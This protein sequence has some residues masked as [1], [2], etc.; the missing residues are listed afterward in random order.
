M[1]FPLLPLLKVKNNND[2]KKSRGRNHSAVTITISFAA[3]PAPAKRIGSL[4][5][6]RDKNSGRAI[7]HGERLCGG[8]MG[9]DQS[10]EESRALQCQQ[11]KRNYLD[12]LI[13]RLPTEVLEIYQPMR[14][15]DFLAVTNERIEGRRIRWSSLQCRLSQLPTPPGAIER[16]LCVRNWFSYARLLRGRYNGF[17]T[18]FHLHPLQVF[19][20]TSCQ[21]L[22]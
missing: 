9:G 17:E 6:S 8:E 16:N 5:K 22:Q 2:E 7:F 1:I 3:K 10:E 12:K 20:I 11:Q 14:G 21:K 15:L 13:L 19:Y 4:T 18:C